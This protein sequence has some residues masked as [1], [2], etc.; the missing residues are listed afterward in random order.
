MENA[1]FWIF[2][3]V[4]VIK[5]GLNIAKKGLRYVISIIFPD[6][7]SSF[8]YGMLYLSIL[9][10]VCYKVFQNKHHSIP[11]YNDDIHQTQD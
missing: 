3:I 11:R 9:F 8:V 10:C 2:C 5:K 7:S 1:V 4:K 6:L